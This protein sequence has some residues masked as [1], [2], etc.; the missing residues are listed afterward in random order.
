MAGETVYTVDEAA[1]AVNVSGRTIRDWV[2]SGRLDAEKVV[3]RRGGRGDY[4]IRHSDLMRAAQKTVAAQSVVQPLQMGLDGEGMTP[5]AVDPMGLN[6]IFP[7]R[8]E[9]LPFTLDMFKGY[10]RFRAAT[11]TPSIPA[12]AELLKIAD[13]EDFRVLF[14]NEEITVASEAATVLTLQAIIEKVA[15]GGFVAAAFEDD[16]KRTVADAL[17]DGTARFYTMNGGVS[18]NKIYLLDGERGRRALSGSANLSLTA[19]NGRQSEILFAWD[20]DEFIWDALSGLWDGLAA[21]APM[22]MDLSA[23]T[24]KNGAVVKPARI[25]DVD[26]FPALRQVKKEGEAVIYTVE[27]DDFAGGVAGLALSAKTLERG[28]GAVLRQHAKGGGGVPVTIRMA[29]VQAIKRD[30]T[31]VNAGEKTDEWKTHLIR[32][33]GVGF[34]FKDGVV[35]RPTDSEGAARDAFTIR[36]YFRGFDN[37]FGANASVMQRVYFGLM[38]WLYFSP[39]LWEIKS[40]LAMSGGGEHSL[41]KMMAVCYGESNCGKTNLIEFL[42]SSMLGQH[43]GLSNVHF[44]AQSWR[45]QRERTGIYPLFYDDVQA[46]RFAGGR[47]PSGDTIAK[48]YDFL[49]TQMEQYPGTIVS[50]NNDARSFTDA[51][52]KRAVFFFASATL[53]ISD[54]DANDR[55]MKEMRVIK[56]AIR[57][58]FYAEYLH[59]MAAIVDALNSETIVDFD[60]MRESTALIIEMMR[61]NLSGGET[62][63]AWASAPLSNADVFQQHLDEVRGTVANRLRSEHMTKDDPPPPNHWRMRREDNQV[64][65]GVED[66]RQ[67][68]AE[69][70]YPDDILVRQHSHGGILVLDAKRLLAFMRLG[71]SE[72]ANWSIPEKG[73]IAKV[74]RIAGR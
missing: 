53:P 4:R 2:K 3:A 49:Y 1:A 13:W 5:Q 22:P 25:V 21:R 40:A 9:I 11:Y 6:V 32:K 42:M 38:G 35:E 39:F 61:E 57:Q 34:I 20:D 58:N 27:P 72:F 24:R 28:A 26:D 8:S 10:E 55:G 46:N 56:N 51:V 68:L 18:H 74:K 62:L 14:G 48:E 47:S 41:V 7:Q 33:P 52:R 30:L 60:Y 59:R 29:K 43:P 54:K 17:A 12:V 65:V 70:V 63:P 71:G 64:I 36:Q 66:A 16:R 15:V 44:T 37:G 67:A 45:T 50:T 69:N 31:R 73:L 19:L 23:L